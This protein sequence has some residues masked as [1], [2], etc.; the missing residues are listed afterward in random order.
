[1]IKIEKKKGNPSTWVKVCCRVRKAADRTSVN[2]STQFAMSS[3]IYRDVENAYN[4]IHG[5]N[6]SNEMPV[7]AALET[8]L[9]SYSNPLQYHA[10]DA[11]DDSSEIR[12]NSATAE[13]Q[14]SQTGVDGREQFSL[15]EFHGTVDVSSGTT[16]WGTMKAY[17]G[18]G[19]LVAVGYMDPGN[20]STSIAGGSAFG[21]ALLF[22]VLLSSLMAMFLQVLALR[23][24]LATQKDLAQACRDAYP[25]RVVAVLWI[26]MEVAICA[27][28][29][30]EVI[31]S[32]VALK[33]LFGLPLVGGVCI[34]A[35]DVLLILFMNGRNFRWLEALVGL[36]I[37]V[38][39]V[40]FIV[41]LCMS[42]PEP[43]PLLV[44][45]L[46][47]TQLLT[48]KKMLFIAVG[49]IGA[50]VM[51]HNL[52]LH[53]S[54]I[55]TRNVAR[56]EASVQKA[57]EFG[58]I[59][60][61]VSLCLALFVNAAILTVSAATFHRNGYTDVATL[62]DAYELL[63]PILNSKAAPILFALALL[64][65]GQNST[66]TGTLSGQIVMEG[67]MTWKL[68]PVM[69]RVVTRLL[70][71]LPAV[72]CVAIGG[73]SSANFLL[74]LSQVILSF[75]LPFAM[76]PLVHI[77]SSPAKM[78]VFA[79]SLPTKIL[80]VIITAVILSLNVVLLV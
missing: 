72:I 36:L 20:W 80:A 46:P 5:Q 11:G 17:I 18:P 67:F 55:L 62:Q 78:G 70:A 2:T 52:F 58:T 54:I 8:E 24:G 10:I 3:G 29:I 4:V 13:T 7:H 61:T 66:L 25:K 15:P 12:D 19:A 71:I 65:S 47:S 16:W 30:A 27:T 48:D 45:F 34:T 9:I 79:N 37:L 42:R 59:D 6:N 32:A 41:Q 14:D 51:P 56:D 21:Y 49:I 38:I 31:G 57:M 35:V 23:V 43:G 77:S 75:A 60:S 44:G 50:T 40:S 63:S 33:L 1:M 53:S 28:D 74:I 69:R 68:T 76:I 22:V 64:A 73:D 26:A 39:T